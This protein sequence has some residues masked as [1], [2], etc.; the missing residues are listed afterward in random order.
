M[1]IEPNHELL[2]A[3][4]SNE[5]KIS[6]VNISQN[7][8]MVHDGDIFLGVKFSQFRSYKSNEGWLYISGK[9]F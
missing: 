1:G 2:V 4:F 9:V 3:Q 7:W 8:C 5:V 6:K